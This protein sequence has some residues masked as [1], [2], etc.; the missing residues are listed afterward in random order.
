M[1]LQWWVSSLSGPGGWMH[2][3]LMFC[4]LQT[5]SQ[6]NSLS[7][8]RVQGRSSSAF[9]CFWLTLCSWRV[10]SCISHSSPFAP[11]VGQSLSCGY[12]WTFLAPSLVGWV[13][14]GWPSDGSEACH[15][16]HSYFLVPHHGL[17]IVSGSS[18]AN[19]RW[20]SRRNRY[21]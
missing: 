14:D 12:F 1:D 5:S 21:P 9:G 6:V 11:L 8:P 18:D 7:S 13:C 19:D 16:V 15:G 2:R 4:T 3:R 17:A 10:S 20:W